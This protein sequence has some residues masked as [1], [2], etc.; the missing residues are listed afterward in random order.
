MQT[1][2]M[3]KDPCMEWIARQG[4]PSPMACPGQHQ[5]PNTD[6]SRTA[7]S[8]YYWRFATHYHSPHHYLVPPDCARRLLTV[9]HARLRHTDLRHTGAS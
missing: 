1:L 7:I 5:L 6:Y 4:T 9:G 8:T 3:V 2:Q